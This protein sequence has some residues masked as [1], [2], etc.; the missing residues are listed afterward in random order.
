ML[1]DGILVQAE[2]L[3]TYKVQFDPFRIIQYVDGE[4]SIILNDNDNLYYD[5][6]EP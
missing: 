6:K 2:D 1:D 4:E 5:S 3:I